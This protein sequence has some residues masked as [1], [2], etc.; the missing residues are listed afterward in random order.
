MKKLLV[1]LVVLAA[2][3]GTGAAAYKPTVEYWKKRSQPKWRTGKVIE[4]DI[5]AVVNATG[6]IKPVLEVKI[7]SFVSGPIDELF[8]DFNQE[9]KK[10]DLL[11]LVDSRIY[12]A[13]KRRAEASLATAR[14][15][16][17]RVEALLNQAK[18]DE[19]RALLLR[20]ENPDFISQ[21]EMDQFKF[22]NSPEID[23]RFQGPSGMAV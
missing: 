18:N 15:E 20:N 5:V 2:L 17:K 22:R 9:V 21:A 19:G 14:A 16:K 3:G 23:S 10:G 13:D 7:G 4:G 8:V 1:I 12:D 11:A 6:T